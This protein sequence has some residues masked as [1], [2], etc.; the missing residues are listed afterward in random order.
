MPS[1]V[2]ILVTSGTS[3]IIATSFL[4]LTCPPLTAIVLTRPIFA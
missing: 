4:A 2:L 3:R 1:D